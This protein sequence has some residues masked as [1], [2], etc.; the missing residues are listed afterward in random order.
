M[1]SFVRSP[2]TP[3]QILR[4]AGIEKDWSS[5]G[6]TSEL[7]RA[8]MT[9]P[10]LL[11]K[12]WSDNDADVFADVFTE[13]GSL[14]MQGIDENGTIVLDRQLCGR[15]EIRAFMREAFQGEFAG[16]HVRGGPLTL[17]FPA[18]SVAVLV[19]WGGQ[20]ERDETEVP[21]HR[22]VR[23]TWVMVRRDGEWKLFSH[24]SSPVRV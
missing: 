1:S 22:E 13:D 16:V 2:R 23:N 21:P 10:L 15:E 6:Y 11:G 5:T 8:V 3:E 24:Q 4:E 7:E 9:V 20:M 12:G 18:E 17:T 14:L 19:T